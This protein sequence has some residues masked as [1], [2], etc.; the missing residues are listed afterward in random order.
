MGGH[1]RKHGRGGTTISVF[2][3]EESSAIWSADSYSVHCN[4]YIA[5]AFSARWPVSLASALFKCDHYH[6]G[7]STVFKIV[8]EE[9]ED[10]CPSLA[11]RSGGFGYPDVRLSSGSRAFVSA[12]LESRLVVLYSAFASSPM[13]RFN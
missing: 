7:G 8:T 13:Q 4:S 10:A 1:Q 11:R 3:Y 12:R 5:A 2:S 9:K 6:Y